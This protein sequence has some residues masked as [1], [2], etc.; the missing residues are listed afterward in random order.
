[1]LIPGKNLCNIGSIRDGEKWPKRDKRKDSDL[2]DLINFDVLSPYTVSK[3]LSGKDLLNK[4]K[5]T[6]DQNSKYY[7]FNNIQIENSS[8]DKGI[9]NYEYGIY[10]FIGRNL[11]NRIKNKQIS[12]INELREILKPQFD[13]QVDKWRDIAGL[14]APEKIIEKLLDDIE[15]DVLNSLDSIKQAFISIYENYYA[16]QWAWNIKTIQNLINKPIEEIIPSDIIELITKYK[17]AVIELNNELLADARKEFT[18][19]AHIGYGIDGDAEIQ[20]ADFISVRGSYEINDI[21]SKI[22]TSTKSEIQIADE[23]INRIK[24]IN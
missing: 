6:Q 4:I 8:V 15:N 13:F 17:T 7:K 16:Y 19:S 12:D 2:L 10:N 5:E 11:I 24:S 18:D 22:E 20:N 1:M 3:L 23:L 9:R 21:V 14:L